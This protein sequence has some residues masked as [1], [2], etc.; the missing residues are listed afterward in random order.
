MSTDLETQI[1]GKRHVSISWWAKAQQR[2]LPR[3]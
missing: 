1:E 2:A 3:V